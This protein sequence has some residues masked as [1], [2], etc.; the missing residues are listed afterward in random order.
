MIIVSSGF[1]DS[2]FISRLFVFTLIFSVY[3]P[4]FKIITSL[5]L[6]ALSTA[7]C[8]ESHGWTKISAVPIPEPNKIRKVVNKMIN[9]FMLIPL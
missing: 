8:I 9:L 2:D 4:G 3:V 5:E 1:P 7:A 6:V